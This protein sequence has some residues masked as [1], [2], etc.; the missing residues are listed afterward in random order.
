M[1][2]LLT[3]TAAFLLAAN[4]QV[5]AQSSKRSNIDYASLGPVASFGHSWMSGGAKQ[6][7]KASAALGIGFIYSKHEHWGW[8]ADLVVS[9]EGYKMEDDDINLEEVVN[10]I[11][12]RLTPKA[13]YF[14]GKYGSNI[15]P[16]V[17]VGP[18]VAFKVDEHITLNDEKVS[19]DDL[20]ALTG[21]DH[22]YDG[23]DLG[24]TGGAGVNFK[25]AGRTWLNLDASYYHGLMDVTD[26]GNANRNIRL[27]VG[28]LFG[29]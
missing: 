21:H 5:Q 20:E 22:I 26:N 25:I 6:D 13:Y 29:L 15:R 23:L 24:L 8:G 10:P 11:Y 4:I 19:K 16:K 18:S 17:Y 28:V 1:K 2:K 27:N 14:F 7:F 3:I 12:L 9:H